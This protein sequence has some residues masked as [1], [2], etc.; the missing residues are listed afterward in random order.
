M[1][2]FIRF[3]FTEIYLKNNELHLFHIKIIDYVG[4]LGAG[5]DYFPKGFVH[6]P[7]QKETEADQDRAR[8]ALS[9]A[10]FTFSLAPLQAGEKPQM[11][12]KKLRKNHIFLE[13]SCAIRP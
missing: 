10:L 4:C 12:Q 6:T 3:Y 2:R 7:D 5:F 11:L 8:R 9:N 13:V 1:I